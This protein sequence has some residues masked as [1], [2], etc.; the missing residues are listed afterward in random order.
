MKWKITYGMCDGTGPYTHEVESE[1]L[2]EFMLA[3]K[4]SGGIN[5]I[6]SMVPSPIVEIRP[7]ATFD[8]WWEAKGEPGK[9]KFISQNIIQWVEET[10]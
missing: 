6:E 1:D 4:R 2:P 9:F 7:G 10:R 5:N 8:E 3:L